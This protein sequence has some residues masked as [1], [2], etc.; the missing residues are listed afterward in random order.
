MTIAPLESF[1]VPDTLPTGEADRLAAAIRPAARKEYS[2]LEL[3][4]TLHRPLFI[5]AVNQQRGRYS[6]LYIV[7]SIPETVSGIPAKVCPV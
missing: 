4:L 5:N 3:D 2:L 7:V 1:R 6:C